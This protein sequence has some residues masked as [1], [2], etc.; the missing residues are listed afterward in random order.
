MRGVPACNI[1]KLEGIIKIFEGCEKAPL[2]SIDDYTL[3][4][5]NKAGELNDEIYECIREWKETV[6]LT[7]SPGEL[8][9]CLRVAKHWGIIEG[10]KMNE[11][12]LNGPFGGFD[13]P[14]MNTFLIKKVNAVKLTNLGEDLLGLLLENKKNEYKQILFWRCLLF[15]PG[16]TI[17]QRLIEDEE[18]YNKQYDEKI[19]IL[20]PDKYSHYIKQ[21]IKYFGLR[22][23]DKSST[24]ILDNKKVG[25]QIIACVILE[26]NLLH[27]EQY[28][29]EI[30]EKISSSLDLSQNSIN[31]FR[32]LE[33][34]NE[35]IDNE[36]ISG[37]ISSRKRQSLPNY[38]KIQM[39]N[40]HSNMSI[41]DVIEN[42]TDR[43]LN[44]IFN[45]DI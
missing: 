16:I 13:G 8:P 39:L 6:N 42:I 19:K 9:E 22:S 40:I 5:K 23:N 3:S 4:K 30:V 32:I 37:H 27:G 17:I 11:N 20:N 34:I 14:L 15:P 10:V 7:N 35:R 21:S 36:I 33:I 2:S 1:E 44:S 26:L 18:C 31:F 25:R 12:E 45:G 28:I 43:E 24:N 41:N 29:D 38:P